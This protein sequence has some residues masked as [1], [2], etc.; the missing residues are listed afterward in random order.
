MAQKEFHPR[1][2]SSPTLDNA[3]VDVDKPLNQPDATKG[4]I[5]Q[6]ILPFIM[7]LAVGG[8]VVLMVTMGG[9]MN[10][11]MMMMPLMLLI[12]GLGMMGMGNGSSTDLNGERRDY[13]LTLRELRTIVHRKGSTMFAAQ[14]SSFPQPALLTPLIGIDEPGA[15]SMWT[16]RATN[17]GGFATPGTDNAKEYRPFL[18]ARIGLGTVELAPEIVSGTLPVAE[19]LEPVTLGAYRRFMRIQ[20]FVPGFP[21]GYYLGRAPFH[22]FVGANDR[23]LPLVRAMIASLTF[24]HSPDTLELAL[25][26][27]DPD[28]EDWGSFKW[29]PHVNDQTRLTADGTARRIYRNLNDFAAALPDSVTERPEFR[30]N[31]HITGG[32]EERGYPHMLVIIDLPDAHVRLPESFGAGGIDGITMLVVRAGANELP[33]ADDAALEL[34]DTG[35]ISTALEP[36]LIRA[37]TMGTAE[38]ATFTRRMAGY[39]TD[40]EI[41]LPGLGDSPAARGR[42][43]YL[44][45]LGIENLETINPYAIW[46]ENARDQH[47]TIPL[48]D[49]IDPATML[50]T[51]DVEWL[52]FSEAGIGGAGPHGALQGMTGTGKSYLLLPMVLSLAMRYSPEECVFALGDFKGAA[53]FRGLEKLPHL[54]ANISNLS[55]HA[56]LLDRFEAVIRGELIKRQ[57]LLDEY[58]QPDILAYRKM[59]DAQ[60]DAYPPMPELFIFIDEFA[61]FIGKHPSFHALFLDICQVGRSLG[62][63]LQLASQIIDESVIRSMKEHISYGVSLLVKSRSAS[64][65][66]INS[67][68]AIN[69]R[70]GEGHAYLHRDVGD[71]NLTMIQ[72]F[73]IDA[74][75]I[76]PVAAVADIGVSGDSINDAPA[77]H[78]SLV[79]FTSISGTTLTLDSDGVVIDEPAPDR[80]GAFTEVRQ[81]LIQTLVRFQDIQPR[82]LWQPTLAAPISFHGAALPTAGTELKIRIGDLDDPANHQRIPYL[83]IPEGKGAHIRITGARRTGKSTTLE[84]IIASAA[85]SYAPTQVQFYLID[86]GNKLQEVANYPNVGALA[87]STDDEKIDRIIAEFRRVVAIRKEEFTRRGVANYT[88]YAESKAQNPVVNDPYGQMFLCIDGITEFLNTPQDGAQAAIVER[89][90]NTLIE[91]AKAGGSRGVHLIIAGDMDTGK[92]KFYNEFGLWILHSSADTGAFT[93]IFDR[94]VRD[95]YKRVPTDQPGRVLEPI[96][97]LHARVY[98]PQLEE[99]APISDNTSDDAHY[100]PNADYGDGIRAFGDHL[101]SLYMAPG[102][103]G[104]LTPVR[105]PRIDTID[106]KIGWY[107]TIW[108]IYM[109]TRTET[110]PRALPL[111]GSA[112]DLSLVQ[113]PTDDPRS[114]PHLT[115]VGDSQ[116]GKSTLVRSLLRSILEQYSPEEAQIYLFDPAY[117]LIDESKILDMRGMLG[118]Y[119]SK[120]DRI[121]STAREIAKLIADRLPDESVTPDAIRDGSWYRGP[122]IFVIIDPASTLTSGGYEEA[123]TDALIEA[124]DTQRDFGRSLGLH[125]F[126]T[127]TTNQWMGRRTSSKFYKALTAANSD[128]M[129]LSGTST[130]NVAG[131]FVTAG[132]KI[133]FARRRPGLGQLYSPSTGHHPVVQTAW[134]PPFELAP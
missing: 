108:P 46:Q 4:P 76:A 93:S 44:K 40:R 89:R 3:R 17:P 80:T 7:I 102:P 42:T 18:A 25:V 94:E 68:A 103:D 127:E 95:S 37:D 86:Y 57:E 73:R 125:V 83:I 1:P 34:D 35:M 30:S 107:E 65:T 72:G 58:V 39:R 116:S 55:K 70:K 50:P 74:P 2:A 15:P 77:E 13:F 61:Q 92:V 110:S 121:A 112:E 26:T 43:P 22:S 71:G 24:N 105:A 88:K 81:A 99:I 64:M 59:R 10:P 91:I 129:L 52:D 109:S 60:P 131:S 41:T 134:H 16:I 96:T 115:I 53:T 124:I 78:S 27:D 123:P 36:A 133:M 12:G 62:V 48:G 87:A 11:M 5:L 126:A 54:L 100:D 113:F 14:E 120:R 90:M 31:E 98:V 119:E 111:G 63:H 51:G 114:V 117:T 6:R 45:A 101:S 79:P 75:Y 118:A 28:G 49:R 97:G 56:D 128:V 33:A 104:Q 66:V 69:L 132:G 47:R 32:G 8:M 82:Q 23:A 106:S 122:K 20:R 21:I 29:L 19:Q 130:E 85:Q 9:A 67:D 38:F 84:T